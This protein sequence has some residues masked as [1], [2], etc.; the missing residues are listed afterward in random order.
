MIKAQY[1]LKKFRYYDP[2]MSV[3][4]QELEGFVFELAEF[5]NASIP[6]PNAELPSHTNLG[7][8][9]YEF[10]CTGRKVIMLIMHL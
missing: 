1:L 6:T 2:T 7:K 3:S 5:S 8:I 4:D 9:I 10:F